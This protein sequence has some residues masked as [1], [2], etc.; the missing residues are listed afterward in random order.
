[1]PSKTVILAF[2]TSAAHCAAALLFDTQ[3]AVQV[4]EPMKKGQA[5]RLFPLLEE[6]LA[7]GG[8]EWKDL[9]HIG[10]GIGPGNFTGIRIGVSA[11]RGLALSLGIPAIGVSMF[12]ALA[13]GTDRPVVTAIKGAADK[14][15]VRA[16]GEEPVLCEPDAM[17]TYPARAE[18]CL[19]GFPSV[20]EL[21]LNHDLETALPA[22]PLPEA[23]ARAVLGRKDK[24]HASPAPLYL[25]AADAAP[26]RDAPPVMLDDA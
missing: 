26:A 16:M 20:D 2:D 21:S 4:I 7:Q 25:K 8:I 15:F 3:I 19:I 12:D 10:V 23:I 22:Y 17:P 9:T 5:E 14:T 1:M 13:I 24:R 18:P 11:A 6:V